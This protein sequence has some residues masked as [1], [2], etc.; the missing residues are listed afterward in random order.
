MGNA[1]TKLHT[2]SGNL[3]SQTEKLKQLGAKAAKSLPNALIE[4]ANEGYLDVA[5][6]A[7]MILA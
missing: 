2:G 4:K 3:V 7:G 5:L 6:A 1:S